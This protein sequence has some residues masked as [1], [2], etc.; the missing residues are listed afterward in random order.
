MKKI[1]CLDCNKEF[2]G[3]S[4]DA[5]LAQ[6]HPHYMEAHQDIMKDGSEDKKKEWFERFNKNWERAPEM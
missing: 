4:P 2:E 6:M 3:A 5:V 1:Q